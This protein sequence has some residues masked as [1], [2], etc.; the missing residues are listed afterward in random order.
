MGVIVY[1]ERWRPT[2]VQIQAQEESGTEL[3]N[4]TYYIPAGVPPDYH[5][6]DDWRLTDACRLGDMARVTQLLESGVNP[7][8]S[9][10]HGNTPLHYAASG[11][12]YNIGLTLLNRQ[13]DI[14][15]IN[16]NGQNAL[17]LS[18]SHGHHTVVKLLLDNNCK[19]KETTLYSGM[20]ALHLA[21][22]N[23]YAEVVKLLLE[24]GV[25]DVILDMVKK[26]AEFYAAT[27]EV[28][29]LFRNHR[30]D[31]YSPENNNNDD[32][33]EKMNELVELEL[34]QNVVI[35]T[36]PEHSFKDCGNNEDE[37][38]TSTDNAQ[39][40][41]S[42]LI[43]TAENDSRT[44]ERPTEKK[45]RAYKS[46]KQNNNGGR[47]A[48]FKDRTEHKSK[49]FVTNQKMEFSEEYKAKMRLSVFDRL[50]KK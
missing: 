32:N 13:A 28:R 21:S 42:S 48:G 19:R 7:N 10:Q 20:T 34:K 4:M 17:H 43:T 46:D 38:V 24:A 35:S 41:V 3:A 37:M 36:E 49:N 26:S 1:L 33:N 12:H 30:A 27:E 8:C 22:K 14:N 39:N 15:A 50:N 9:D 40:V 29:A 16:K 47:T 2:D 31:I 45:G 18:S 5:T 11:G 44:D 23:G 6:G 25:D